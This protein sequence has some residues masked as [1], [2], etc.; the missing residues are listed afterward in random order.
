MLLLHFLTNI[1]LAA[2]AHTPIQN[3]SW[4]MLVEDLDEFNKHPWG[5]M[6]WNFFHGQVR[7]YVMK[8]ASKAESKQKINFPGFVYPLQVWA[9]ECLPV[10][11]ALKLCQQVSETAVPLMRRWKTNVHVL[12]SRLK[13]INF[14]DVEFRPLGA[15]VEDILPQKKKQK[16][17][18]K[19][20]LALAS[21]STSRSNNDDSRVSTLPSYI[22]TIT[23]SVDIQVYNLYQL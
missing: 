3:M 17:K 11:T 10:L 13:E 2:P 18:Q 21:T 19:Q 20:V 14:Q 22:S 12:D 23:T 7:K 5:N 9:Y 1:L 16:F 6:A 8:M 15:E 4:A